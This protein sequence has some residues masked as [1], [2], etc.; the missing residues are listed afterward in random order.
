MTQATT[1]SFRCLAVAPG[2]VMT[3]PQIKSITVV[4]IIRHTNHGSH[5]P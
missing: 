2:R 3:R 1:A 5:Q 4:N